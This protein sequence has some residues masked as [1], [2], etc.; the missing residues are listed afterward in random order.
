MEDDT[1][2]GRSLGGVEGE[3][4][5]KEEG[6]GGEDVGRR[7]LTLRAQVCIGTNT[8]VY[9]YLSQRP[10]TLLV[11]YF[12]MTTKIIMCNGLNTLIYIYEFLRPKILL[13][14]YRS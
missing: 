3:A 12:L 10:K 9:L 13:M 14:P 8:L 1:V 2:G 6:R 4:T 11:S 5:E 7:P